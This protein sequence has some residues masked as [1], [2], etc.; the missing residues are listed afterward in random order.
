M[1]GGPG[2]HTTF[3]VS[4]ARMNQIQMVGTRK[5]PPRP[6]R[7]EGAL[8]VRCLQSVGQLGG[9][10]LLRHLL[11][12]ARLDQL[13]DHGGV[14]ASVTVA[15][16]RSRGRSRGLL[17]DRIPEDSVDCRDGPTLRESI[18]ARH[19]H[20]ITPVEDAFVLL[21]GNDVR[22]TSLAVP[23]IGVVHPLHLA[24]VDSLDAELLALR[25]WLALRVPLAIVHVG[26]A[27]LR[28]GESETLDADLDTLRVSVPELLPDLPCESGTC[29]ARHLEIDGHLRGY[30]LALLRGL[31]LQ[32]EHGA[33]TTGPNIFETCN[34]HIRI[35]RI[36]RH[37]I[38]LSLKT[39]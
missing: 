28:S 26:V 2:G 15:C 23:G 29:L 20:R 25:E 37:G 17:L 16:G 5:Q 14:T 36:S 38:N 39:T 12:D 3:I 34:E 10:G 24:T 7:I 13:G 6:F 21:G 18:L 9:G 19:R 27:V 4:H 33:V 30:L 32:T 11:G 22:A 35:L 8:S 1:L 31:T